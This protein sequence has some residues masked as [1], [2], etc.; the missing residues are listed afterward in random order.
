MATLSRSVLVAC[1]LVTAIPQI[2]S[3]GDLRVAVGGGAAAVAYYPCSHPDSGCSTPRTTTMGPAPL[4]LAGYRGRIALRNGF[5][6]RVGGTMSAVLIAPGSDTRGSVIS[7]AGEF[8]IEHGPAA[9]DVFSGFSRV[10]L[11]TDQMSGAAGTMLIGGAATV[12]VSADLAV[13]ARLDLN[14]MM[15]GSAASAFLGLGLEWTP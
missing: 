6:L 10:Q 3:A 12:R 7:G 15:H 2:S 5:A 1:A 14:A 4:V 9:L 11:A 13:F 8:G